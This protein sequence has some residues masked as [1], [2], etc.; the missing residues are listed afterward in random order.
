MNNKYLVKELEKINL[1][2]EE[3]RQNIMKNNGSIQTIE[4]IPDWIKEIYKTVWEI[5]VVDLIDMSASRGRFI[6]QSQSFNIFV[7]SPSVNKISSLLMYGWKKGLKTGMYY[8]RIKSAANPIQFTVDSPDGSA[9]VDTEIERCKP[10]C[11]VC[12]S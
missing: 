11:I 3:T 2:N 4:Y 9:I 7:D 5:K 1:W 10:E 8:L 6:D 12:E